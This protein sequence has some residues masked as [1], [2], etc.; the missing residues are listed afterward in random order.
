MFLRE[1]AI[2]VKIAA[3]ANVIDKLRKDAYNVSN[4]KENVMMEK[5][6]ISLVRESAVGVSR[7]GYKEFRSGTANEEFDRFA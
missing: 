1:G 7:Y 6:C 3:G 4:F 5:R 2:P